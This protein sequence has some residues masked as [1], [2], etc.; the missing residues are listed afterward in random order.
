MTRPI[1]SIRLRVSESDCKRAFLA[2]GTHTR[3]P[4]LL[5]IKCPAIYR[6]KRVGSVSVEVSR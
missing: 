1:L 6:I 3:H 5:I 2:L 4:I